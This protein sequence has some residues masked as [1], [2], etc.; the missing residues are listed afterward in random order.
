MDLSLNYYQSI[1]E[2]QKAIERVGRQ[3]T[4]SGFISRVLSD[5]FGVVASYVAMYVG[6][7]ILYRL[8]RGHFPRPSLILFG[9]L[10]YVTGLP[11]IGEIYSR[12]VSSTN[13]DMR[14]QRCLSDLSKYEI[15]TGGGNDCVTARE[16]C[17]IDPPTD[18]ESIC[19]P[20]LADCMGS[21]AISAWPSF[22]LEDD[23]Q[24]CV[25]TYNTCMDDNNPDNRIQPCNT[26][27]TECINNLP[28]GYT[29]GDM[30]ACDDQY[31][32]CLDGSSP[33]PPESEASR[34]DNKYNNCIDTVNREAAEYYSTLGR[35]GNPYP[36]NPR[37]FTE[38]YQTCEDRHDRCNRGQ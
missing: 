12:F 8:A 14:Y 38:D 15:L 33:L 34:C 26:Q 36:E 6:M 5:I 32:S 17:Y 9:P 13:C 1:E 29:F 30:S 35:D 16:A 7:S 27:Y 31:L 22:P 37:D 4:P 3:N 2:T 25:D 19:G 20:P 23:L 11:I 18:A 21:A 28:E 10:Y 24:P